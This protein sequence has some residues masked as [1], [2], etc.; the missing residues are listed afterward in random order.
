MSEERAS[1]IG[2]AKESA[3]LSFEYMDTPGEDPIPEMGW[4]GKDDQLGVM[5]FAVDFD[6]PNEKNA[7]FDMMTCHL[8]IE[9][10]QEATFFSTVWEVRGEQVEQ[11]KAEGKP[12][13]SDFSG[14]SEAILLLHV[15][16]DVEAVWHAPITRYADKPPTLGA[17]AHVERRFTGRMRDAIYIGVRMGSAIPGGLAQSLREQM[18]KDG[19]EKTMA[20]MIRAF[21][22]ARQMAEVE[23]N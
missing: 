18:N 1:L 14:R 22:T 15:T 2:M 21:R 9:Q 12:A 23:R 3:R 10:A 13:P 20:M 17:W 19:P 6:S 16:P 5:A 7:I 4:R 8:A 11:W